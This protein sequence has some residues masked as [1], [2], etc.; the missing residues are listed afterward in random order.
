MNIMRIWHGYT[1]PENADAYEQLLKTDILPGIHR[2]DGY[3]GAHLLRREAGGEVELITI[4]LGFVGGRRKVRRRGT[5]RRG[6]AGAGARASHEV[7]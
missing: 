7:R 5:W 1:A 2:I 4:H 3:L 6:G